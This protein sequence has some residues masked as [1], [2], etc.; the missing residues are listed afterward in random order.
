MRWIGAAS[1]W[2]LCLNQVNANWWIRG[3]SRAARHRRS[4][5]RRSP[6]GASGAVL[7]PRPLDGTTTTPAVKATGDFADVR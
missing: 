7:L 4:P 6:A 5:R 1:L 2:R 3:A